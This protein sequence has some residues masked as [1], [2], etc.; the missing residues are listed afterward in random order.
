MNNATRKVIGEIIYELETK[1][2]MPLLD[3][4]SQIESLMEEEQ[5][6]YDNLQDT[7]FA[8]SERASVM[9]SAVSSMEE[10]IGELQNIDE[11]SSEEDIKAA[12]DSAV[13]S[14]REIE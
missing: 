4:A 6:K 10:A 8:D 12:R 5:N 2:A 14:L 11:T 1:K 13:I 9:E 7:P 3:V